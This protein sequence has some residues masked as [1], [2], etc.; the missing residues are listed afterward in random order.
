MSHE[1][2]GDGVRCDH[3]DTLGIPY[4]YRGRTFSGLT[5]NRGERLCSR[6]LDAEMTREAN[7]PTGPMQVPARD[8]ITPCA[9]RYR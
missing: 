1:F 5:P 6:C 8:Y 3:C 9:Y 2:P 4:T 7:E